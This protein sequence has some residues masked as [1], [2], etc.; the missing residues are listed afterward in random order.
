MAPF[1]MNE[2][3]IFICI[4]LRASKCCDAVFFPFRYREMTS[5][6]SISQIICSFLIYYHVCFFV[7]K[8]FIFVVLARA[9]AKMCSVQCGY[10]LDK[11]WD[12]N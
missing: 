6:A 1:L 4:C 5:Q 8:Y 7:W 3:R 9:Y 2:K 10:T 12:D 11:C